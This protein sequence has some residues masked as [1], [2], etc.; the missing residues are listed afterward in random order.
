VIVFD[1][2][3]IGPWVC[4]RTGG[5]YEP[6]TSAAVAMEEDGAITAGVLYDMF[7]GRSICMHVAVEKPVTRGFTRTAFD[8][9]FN[10]LKVNKVIGLVD[11]TNAKA[12]RFDKHLGFVEEARIEGAGKSGDLI[13][14]TMT[15]QQCRWIKE[16]SHG[17]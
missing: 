17:R 11:S 5:R 16:A 2:D 9:P 10:Q 12:L 7:N 6:S 14:L 1:A 15:R 13:I 8:Y 3:R 4:E